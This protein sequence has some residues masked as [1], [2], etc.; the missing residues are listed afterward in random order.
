MNCLTVTQRLITHQRLPQLVYAGECGSAL[1]LSGRPVPAGAGQPVTDLAPSSATLAVDR[2]LE[3][4][5]RESGARV[6]VSCAPNIG[7]HK[8][9]R[10]MG[11]VAASK[12]AM[13][14]LTR[15]IPVGRFSAGVRS[16]PVSRATT[17]LGRH[18]LSGSAPPACRADRF[19]RRGRGGG[20][21]AGCRRAGLSR[22]TG[23][24]HRWRY[25]RVT[26]LASGRESTMNPTK[27]LQ[28]EAVATIGGPVASQQPDWSLHPCLQVVRDQ[29]RLIDDFVSLEE[30]S[31]LQTH[32]ARAASG[33]VEILQLGD[34][35]EDP[36]TATREQVLRSANF[37]A[38][39]AD[40]MSRASGSSTLRVGRLG[41]Q[42]A[43]PRSRSTE[44]VDGIEHSTFR[45]HMVNSPEDR[46]HDPHR[47]IGAALA[48]QKTHAVLAQHH[49]DRIDCGRTWTSHEALVL[50]Y[51]TALVRS[52]GYA[53]Y[54]ASTHWPWIGNRTRQVEGAHVAFLAVLVNPI[55]IKID[56]TT[57]PDELVQLCEALDRERIPG[58]LTLV[59]RLG[60]G[61]DRQ[62]LPK[63]V[64]AVR[65]AGHAVIWMCDPMHANTYLAP[66]GLK[67]RS[68]QAIVREIEEF[69]AG[70]ALG[71]GIPIGLHLEATADNVLECVDEA[72][73]AARLGPSYRTLCDPRLNPQQ[74]HLVVEA[75][76]AARHG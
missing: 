57:S 34:C 55:A 64:Q 61:V 67:T 17:A 50:D 29:L 40:Q 11:A 9:S 12:T 4:E 33:G 76:A 48:A 59:A 58:R 69:V 70:V 20:R 26:V 56:R 27:E 74:T 39:I 7:V 21:M 63:L 6:I 13:S 14:V 28:L 32:L 62:Y 51:E 3:I 75:W 46:A 38:E 10:N 42:Y 1:D 65:D 47:M 73:D 18:A 68:V 22:E 41:G 66:R 30:I 8:L 25:D 36:A 19:H 45:G 23:S 72:R 49:R 16:G 37:I 2:Q 54:L 71:G 31:A 35:A 43:K 60:V 24:R 52:H 15:D 53:R 44:L 5:R